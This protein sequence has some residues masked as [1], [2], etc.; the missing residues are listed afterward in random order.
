MTMLP[1]PSSGAKGKRP[2]ALHEAHADSLQ[3]GPRMWLLIHLCLENLLLFYF[4]MSNWVVWPGG[5]CPGA[6]SRPSEARK[7]CS[8]SPSLFIELWAALVNRVHTAP[9]HP[10]RPACVLS[11]RSPPRAQSHRSL[12]V[13][14]TDGMRLLKPRPEAHSGQRPPP[15]ARSSEPRR[16]SLVSLGPAPKDG[17]CHAWAQEQT[18]PPRKKRGL[19]PPTGHREETR[20]PAGRMFKINVLLKHTVS[21]NVN[22]N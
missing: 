6:V 4:F 22:G 8:C 21:A 16:T 13:S 9:Q 19:N 15:G 1:S 7:P 12:R 18:S 20:C 5:K 14:R 11:T 17:R 10:L 2:A 3:M